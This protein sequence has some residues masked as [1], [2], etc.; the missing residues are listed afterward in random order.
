M[1][2]DT[3]L[4]GPLITFANKIAVAWKFGGRKWDQTRGAAYQTY[5]SDAR[6]RTGDEDGF[7]EETRGVEEGHGAGERAESISSRYQASGQRPIAESPM[8]MMQSN[9]NHDQVDEGDIQVRRWNRLLS[10][11]KSHGMDLSPSAFHVERRPRAG[12][13]HPPSSPTP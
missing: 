9:S 1:C 8:L 6:T 11:L 13:V 2:R 12:I 3:G 10:W 4:F 7:A 5:C